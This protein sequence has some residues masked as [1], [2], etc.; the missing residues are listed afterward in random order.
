MD[1]LAGPALEPALCPDHPGF[2]GRPRAAAGDTVPLPTAQGYTRSLSVWDATPVTL[3]VC[4]ARP[5]PPIPRLAVS[6]D[7]MTWLATAA[8][9]LTTSTSIRS[10][11]VWA[12]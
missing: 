11:V 10:K 8:V 9:R 6:L 4:D 5:H 1:Q 7:K 12:G 3:C 2:P